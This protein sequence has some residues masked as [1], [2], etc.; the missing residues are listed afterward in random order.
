MSAPSFTLPDGYSG[1]V[2]TNPADDESMI[3]IYGYTPWLSANSAA[4]ACFAALLGVHLAWMIKY[5]RTRIFQFLLVLACAMELVGYI[6]RTMSSK[7]P[8]I[9]IRFV[10]N[11][12]FIVCAPIFVSAAIYLGLA[13][14]L[15]GLPPRSSPLGAKALIGVFVAIDTV[16]IL[17]QI[18]GAALIGSGYSAQADGR[19]P[20]IEPEDANRILLA[21]LSV[22]SA[23]SVLFIFIL[24]RVIV[25]GSR[26]ASGVRTALYLLLASDLLIVLRTLFR[27]AES[28]EG[29]FSGVSANQGLFVALEMIPVIVAVAL[30]AFVPLGRSMVIEADGEREWNGRDKA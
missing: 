2:N 25:R 7:N 12:F 11:Y 3:A 22:Q 9:V 16:T 10:L 17:T 18:V 1:P 23:A 30:W 5:K 24:V 6:F 27:L 26:A 15:P 21:G 20:A 13:K 8:F 14:L 28:A 19:K 29:T 4:V